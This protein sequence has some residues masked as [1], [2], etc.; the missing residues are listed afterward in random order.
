MLA[1]L[2]PCFLGLVLLIGMYL[3]FKYRNPYKWIH[4]V[5]F[6]GSGK[7]TLCVKL[8]QQHLKKGWTV[9]SNIKIPGAYLIDPNDL[10]QFFVSPKSIIILDE[11]GLVWDNRD[12]KS[13][14]QH[15]RDWAK[16]HR[17]HKHKV[18]SFSQ[19]MDYDLKLRSVTDKLYLLVNY[20]GWFSAAKE[21]KMKW[22]AVQPDANAE[23]RIAQGMVIQ[24]FILAP[25]GARIYTFIPRW[26]KYFDS[27]ETKAL[28][29]K[30]YE[31][32]QYP[33]KMPKRFIPK[34][35]RNSK[36]I[37]TPSGPA[38][39]QSGPTFLNNSESQ[40]PESAPPAERSKPE[41]K[42][43]PDESGFEASETNLD[44]LAS[45]FS[46]PPLSSEGTMEQDP[47]SLGGP[48]TA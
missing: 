29:H 4:T 27:F 34:H 6:P 46:T 8:T 39:A 43:K 16:Y 48:Y 3:S 15:S 23:G 17:H 47:P 28:P 41:R 30:E 2:L 12:F 14:K 1:Y 7:T 40:P 32:I 20:F 37:Q 38:A 18:Y 19:S 35:L 9:Y 44:L 33:A 45:L 42:A 21:V 24:P 36:F 5:G 11:I 13:F 25:F 22:V 31:A 10:G 26:V